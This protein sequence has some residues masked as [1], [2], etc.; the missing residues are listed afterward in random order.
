MKRETGIP[1]ENILPLARDFASHIT[2]NFLCNFLFASSDF[3]EGLT[4]LKNKRQNAIDISVL[5]EF[6]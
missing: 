4:F 5:R 1:P 3:V 2:D 6:V